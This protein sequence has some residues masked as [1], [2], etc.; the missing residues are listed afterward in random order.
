MKR[1]IAAL[2]LLAL[3][4]P[5]FAQNV[6][7]NCINPSGSGLTAWTPCSAT[8]PLNITGS[9]SATNPSVSTTGTAVPGS[10]TYVGMNVSGNLVGLTGTG[11][12]LN[13]QLGAA[14]PAGANTIGAVTQSGTWNV[15]V[16]AAL[17]AGSA[18]IGRTGI[19]QTTP[20]TT[21]AVVLAP[22]SATGGA[23]A[24]QATQAAASNSV[25]KASAGNLYS[26]DVTVG[27][28]SGWV[29]VFDA[30]SLPA[31]GATTTTLKYCWPAISNGTV[32]GMSRSWHIPISFANGIVVGF[33]STACNSLTA[34]ATAFFYGQVQ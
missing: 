15:T 23:V 13:V 24:P 6:N 2:W 34:S 27:A 20:G 5:A 3:C 22:T 12:N 8:N 32:G 7:L 9:I 4:P 14:I 19:D 30:T 28:T 29:M 17:P 33:S 18:I 16:N 21:N 26:I 1:I 10:G 11:S 31:N 25:F